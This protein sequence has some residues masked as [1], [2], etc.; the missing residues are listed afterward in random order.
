MPRIALNVI[1]W[2]CGSFLPIIIHPRSNQVDLGCGNYA[3]M[4]RHVCMRNN[5]NKDAYGT[6]GA[7]GKKIPFYVLFF[8]KV[9]ASYGHIFALI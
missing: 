9:T 8:F 1:A 6:I 2:E 5:P 3:F 7:G 4:S